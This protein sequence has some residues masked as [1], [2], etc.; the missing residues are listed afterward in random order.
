MKKKIAF[1]LTFIIIVLINTNIYAKYVIEYTNTVANIK[2]D[3]IPPSIQLISINNTNT[4]YEGYA[5]QTHTITARIKV[6]EK[7]IKENNFNTDNI[8]ILVG[9]IKTIPDVYEI[10]KVVGSSKMIIYEIKLNK[11]LGNGKLKI[12]VRE[13]TIEDISNNKNK[14]ET[15]DTDIEIDNIAPVVTFTQN[16]GNN[17]KII[18]NLVANEEIIKVNGWDLSQDNQTL[19]KEFACNVTYPF[20]VTDYAQNTSNVD[21]SITKATNIKIRYG[22][23]LYGGSWSLGQGNNEIVG[24]EEIA[25]NPI[26]KTEMISLHTEGNIEKDFI[27]IQNY[28][29]TYWGEGKKGISYTYETIYQH[30]YNPTEDTYNSMASGTFV[31]INNE[32]SIILGGDGA[33]R[34]GSKPVSGG[35]AIPAEIAN[36]YLFGVSGLRVKLKDNSEYSIVYQIWV[37]GYGW[38]KPA[39]DGEETTYA[40]DKPIGAYRMSLIPKTEKQYLIDFWSKDIGTNNMK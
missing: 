16:D 15:F 2:I 35:T 6:L 24:K 31:N 11:I 1:L 29:Y 30:G 19:L 40:H 4:L 25:K 39:S 5:N 27:Q 26:Y 14:E 17:G 8:E 21:I 28:M 34:A 18:A 36:Q 9:D 38:Q 22:A 13:G 3:T 37:N 33:N 12:K 7:N 23:C 32:L 10:K 20:K